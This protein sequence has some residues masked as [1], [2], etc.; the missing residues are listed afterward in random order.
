MK[1]AIEVINISKKYHLG[2]RQPY[3]TLR[4]SLADLFKPETKAGLSSDEFWA[5]KDVS[6][7]IQP[8]EI[9]GVIGRNGAGKST[10]L[11]VLSRI[12]YPTS[13][14]A[15]L[16]GRVTS[17]LEVGTG[18]SPELTGREN[19]FLN[20]AILGMGQKEIKTKFDQIVGFSEIGKFIDTQVKY[21]SSGMYMR[22]AFAVAAHLESE[23]L[24]IDEVLAVGDVQFQRKSLG[25]MENLSRN[26]GRTVV[27]VSHNMEAV[28]GLCN[29]AILLDGGRIA[30]AGE[31]GMVIEKYL[32]RADKNI[33]ERNWEKSKRPPG[34]K[35]I[36]LLSA[37][38]I[39]KLSVGQTVIDVNTPMD[40]EFRFEN[41][42]PNQVINLS[43]VL[44]TS[45]K[46]CVFN[47]ISEIKKLSPGTH[48]AVCHFPGGLLNDNSYYI[49]IM[50]VKDTSRGYFDMDDILSF[51][52][53][54]NRD[55]GNWYGKWIG[56]V[57]P[58]L[59]FTFS[60]DV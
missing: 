56:A 19:I 18:F 55:M 1:P 50:F 16:R 43:L 35:S 17:M 46:E 31:T 27:F 20:G 54:D 58:K 2:Q 59:D 14:K 4:D 11:K 49:Q 7:S 13:G 52:V 6:L 21:Y 9:V 12:T 57:R 44:W 36:K 8:G 41:Y 33:L 3:I 45:K 26:E 51:D 5:L 25:R 38:I 32:H 34:N 40:V 24:L 42:L 28:R 53:H 39:P 10:L 60:K 29:R 23:I 15:I 37:R 48:R 22:L 30:V 47:T